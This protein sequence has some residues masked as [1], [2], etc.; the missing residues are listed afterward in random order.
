MLLNISLGFCFSVGL[1]SAVPATVVRSPFLHPPRDA[2]MKWSIHVENY[3]LRIYRRDACQPESV[4]GLIER[5]ET[6]EIHTFRTLKALITIL[7]GSAPDI[8]EAATETPRS[9]FT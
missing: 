4:V 5:V 8:K 9:S 6:G 3:I 2:K 7:A 1:D